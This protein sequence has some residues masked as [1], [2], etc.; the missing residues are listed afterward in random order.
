M[1][2]DFEVNPSV[3][4]P[5]PETEALTEVALR[6]IEEATPRPGIGVGG[7]TFASGSEPAREC[8]GSVSPSPLCVADIGTGSGV[9]A[10]TIALR[11]PSAAVYATDSSAD[12]LVVARRNAERAGVLDRIT[13]LEG[14]LFEPLR[15]LDPPGRLSMIVSNPPYV[16]TG[17]LDGLEPEV[18]DF[19]PRGALDGGPD[20]L[21]YLRKIA[22]DGPAFLA[23]GG[24]VVLEVG[25]GQAEEVR[26]ML[27]EGAEDVEVHR[28]YAGRDRIVTG[29]KAW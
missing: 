29:R 7:A 12:A 13:F 25:D 22:H 28:D 21:D 8:G 17:D 4:I 18:R 1:F 26:E 10:V 2:S 20:G 14:P 6:M 15:E 27:R 19:E 3:L 24:A 23:P 5:R 11:R 9:I 16:P